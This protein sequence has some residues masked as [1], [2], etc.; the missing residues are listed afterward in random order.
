M[1]ELARELEQGWREQAAC[2]GQ[3]VNMFVTSADE[4]RSGRPP[5]EAMRVCRSC[6]V[7]LDCFRAAGTDDGV[8]GG[9]TE[10]HRRQIRTGRMSVVEAFAA[11][12]RVASMRTDEERRPDVDVCSV[13]GCDGPRHAREL[14]GLHYRRFVET[15]STDAP[16][17]SVSVDDALERV[18]AIA[19]EH[20]MTVDD[21][22][23]DRRS[24]PF[25]AARQEAMVTLVGLGMSASAV[26]RLMGR[27]HTTVLHAVRKVAA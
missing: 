17:E 26:G 20:G 5:I 18:R 4:D 16:Q 8:W 13:E 7:R 15:G 27:D 3:D 25:I 11:G 24:S 21:L 2:V 1:R 19:V 10:H 23:S 9:T 14:C 6:D 12:D 22:M